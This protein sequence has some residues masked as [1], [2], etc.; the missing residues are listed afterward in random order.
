MK[1][2][3]CSI[4]GNKLTL[5]EVGDEGLVPYCLNCNRPIFNHNS[6]CVILMI[7]N[8]LNQLMVIKQ[9]YGFQKFVLVAGYVKYM[10]TVEETIR[11]EVFEETGQIVDDFSFFKSIV[12]E[13]SD[14]L[15]LA[16]HVN[17]KMRLIK[18]SKELSFA[19]WMNI[20]EAIDALK[21]ASLA[22]GLVKEY[23]GK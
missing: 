1:N 7:E 10:A 18:I 9:S 4:C 15:M 2:D 6:L 13:K 16:F 22:Y 3:F 23:Y 11:D 19:T 14:N 12:H 5:K 8:E 17:V 21:E 20:D